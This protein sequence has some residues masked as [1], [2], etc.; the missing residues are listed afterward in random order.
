METE[1]CAVLSLKSKCVR[2]ALYAVWV[3]GKIKKRKGLSP[4]SCVMYDVWR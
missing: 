2:Y 3:W 4:S 1:K